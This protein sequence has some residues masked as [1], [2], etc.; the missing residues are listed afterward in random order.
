MSKLTGP[1]L[2]LSANGQIGKT[3]VYGDWKGVK[4]ARQ[5]VVPANPNTGGQQTQR[6]YMT[7]ALELWHSVTSVLNALDLSNINRAATLEAKIM[8]GFNYYVKNYINSKVAGANP[9][10]LFN[11]TEVDDSAGSVQITGESAAAT[12]SVKMRWG[13]SPTAM[14]YLVT[15][16]EGAVA[17]TTHTFDVATTTAGQ[18]MYYQ[19][20][21]LTVNSEVTLGVGKLLV[22]A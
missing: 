14:L 22:T 2:S 1:L 16:T 17:G 19:I 21:D 13:F 10:Q 4:Y 20:Y 18:I 8:S 12:L 3:I 11:T 5:Y 7:T 9:V 15:R 6:G